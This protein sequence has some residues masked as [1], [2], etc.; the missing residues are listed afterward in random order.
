MPERNCLREPFKSDLAVTGESSRYQTWASWILPTC[1]YAHTVY[2]L[3]LHTRQLDPLDKRTL[4]EKEHD[5]NGQ[6]HHSGCCH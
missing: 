2:F 6:N 4:C 5:D 1:G 3:S